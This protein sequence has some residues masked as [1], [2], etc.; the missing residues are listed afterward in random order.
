[1]N[2]APPPMCRQVHGSRA[3]TRS[4]LVYAVDAG[5]GQLR[6]RLAGDPR[7]ISMQN[8]RAVTVLNASS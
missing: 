8:R 2:G 4:R 1:M 3:A 6:G 7:V 5:Y